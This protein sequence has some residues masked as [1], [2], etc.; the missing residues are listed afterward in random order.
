MG[1]SR[2]FIV[3]FPELE[4]G[5]LVWIEAFRKANDFESFQAIRP[6]FTLVFPDEQN[7]LEVL[8]AEAHARLKDVEKIRFEIKRALLMPPMES[9]QFSYVFL[10]PDL[11]LAAIGRLHDLLYSKRLR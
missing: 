2:S 8:K 4:S 1:E 6:H 10:V 5:A 11:G 9:S 3:A 7:P